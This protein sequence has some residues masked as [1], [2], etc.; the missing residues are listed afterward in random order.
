MACGRQEAA[1][2]TAGAGASTAPRSS[3][4]LSHVKPS[5]TWAALCLAPPSHMATRTWP[6]WRPGGRQAGWTCPARRPKHIAGG[7]R[8]QA[9]QEVQ[10]ALLRP[11]L[12]GP[13]PPLSEKGV[14][15]AASSTS[16]VEASRPTSLRWPALQQPAPSTPV[17]ASL[18][19]GAFA[20]G[21]ASVVLAH[22]GHAFL[23]RR[24]LCSGDLRSSPAA[25]PGCGLAWH[26]RLQELCKAATP[27]QQSV[28]LGAEHCV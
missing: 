25:R 12:A 8:K 23:K 21:S 16:S 28:Q 11:A 22:P 4:V 9:P 10:V 14:P 5:L 19:R 18:A 15:A 13:L 3:A 27:S 2:A 17:V 6:Q 24:A 7:R 26:R 20:L 1:C